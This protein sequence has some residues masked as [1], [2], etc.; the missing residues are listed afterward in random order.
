[1]STPKDVGGK[2]AEKVKHAQGD[3][4]EEHLQSITKILPVTEQADYTKKSGGGIIGRAFTDRLGT[5]WVRPGQKG[6]KR[7]G[8]LPCE[9]LAA[10]ETL[11]NKLD[12]NGMWAS[13]YLIREDLGGCNLY[14]KVDKGMKHL[15]R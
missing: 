7:G 8:R 5:A 14:V 10:L 1:M 4:L 11:G 6:H 15:L 12:A 13:T 3:N 2:V 9:V